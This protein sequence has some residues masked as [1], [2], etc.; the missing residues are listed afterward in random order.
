MKPKINFRKSDRLVIDGIVAAAERIDRDIPDKQSGF[1]RLRFP[2]RP[3][4]IKRWR[5][6]INKVVTINYNVEGK[7]TSFAIGIKAD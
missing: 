6:A 3:G 7:A 1:Q 4:R 5:N 2:G